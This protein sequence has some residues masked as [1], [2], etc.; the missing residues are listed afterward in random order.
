MHDDPASKVPVGD[1]KDLAC[2]FL[3]DNS[4]K[5]IEESQLAF[6]TKAVLGALSTVDPGGKTSCQL[7][8]GLPMLPNLARQTTA[9]QANDRSSGR[10]VSHIADTY[11][12]IIWDWL[13]SLTEGWSTIDPEKGLDIF[14]LHTGEC[15][16]LTALDR[17]IRSDV[18]RL[19]RATPGYVGAFT[20]DPGNAV[21]RGAFA[22]L[23]IYKAAIMDGTV[24]QEL[25]IEGDPDFP[26]NGA[27]SFKP[28][29]LA[30]K[31]YYWLA[32]NGP[33]DVPIA[34]SSQRG[35]QTVAALSRKHAGRIE[36]RVIEAIQS[37]FGLKLPGRPYAFE[38]VGTP[39][40]V[41]QALMPEGKFTHYLFSEEHEDGGPKAEFFIHT[42]GIN[43]DD[44]RYLAAQF[45]EGLL[46]AKPEDVE[47]KDWGD[48]YGARFNAY[49]RVQGRSGVTAV[50]KTGWMMRPGALPSLASAMPD[51]PRRNVVQ[52]PPPQILP[53]GLKTDGDW[54][55]LWEWADAAGMRALEE[56]VPT[57]LFLQGYP[58]IAEG[59]MGF[60]R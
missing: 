30:W 12:F 41:L 18:D 15:V 11:K 6:F 32:E 10:T 31:P 19:L 9:V 29:G 43:P 47:L 26:V 57:P 42:L 53:P 36:H 60:G 45:Y 4:A 48:G 34:P 21:H 16:T 33:P 1:E 49:M 20:L 14:R 54:K 17:S 13:D 7:R 58:P 23:L 37:V 35:A 39:A 27:D 46:A 25:S 55:T 22:D 28:G 52:P 51:D 2:A 38:V 50:V 40:D 8:V 59:E 56:V 3:F 5:G 24:F 44:W